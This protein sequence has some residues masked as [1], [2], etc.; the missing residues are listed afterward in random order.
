MKADGTRVRAHFRWAAGARNQMAVLAVITVVVIGMS[1]N[2][3]QVDGGDGGGPLPRPMLSYPVKLPGVDQ[4]AARPVPRATVSYPVRL[5]GAE[6][7]AK[8]VPRA[9]VSYP[10]PWAGER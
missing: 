8:P 6:Q 2:G 9:T 7:R 1:N 10:I 3:A 4:Q 5:P